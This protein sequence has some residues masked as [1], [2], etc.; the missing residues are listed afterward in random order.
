MLV[1]VDDL[2]A[3]TSQ[4]PSNMIEVRWITL[5]VAHPHRKRSL[6]TMPPL[7]PS[8]ATPMKSSR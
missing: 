8:T 7:M 4:K 5:F 3:I 2:S 6:A 1:S